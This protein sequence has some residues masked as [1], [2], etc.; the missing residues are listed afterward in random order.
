MTVKGTARAKPAAPTAKAQAAGGA[1]AAPK[2]A[3]S[4]K[5]KTAGASNRK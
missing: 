4:P 3:A 2:A 1:K 5:P